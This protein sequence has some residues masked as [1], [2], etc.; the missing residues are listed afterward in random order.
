MRYPAISQTKSEP[1]PSRLRQSPCPALAARTPLL[2]PSLLAPPAPP[3]IPTAV[4]RD[5]L[6]GGVR[7]L[8]AGRAGSAQLYR[9]RAGSAQLDWYST[10]AAA[11]SRS[12]FPLLGSVAGWSGLSDR[13]HRVCLASAPGGTRVRGSGV[14]TAANGVAPLTGRRARLVLHCICIVYALVCLLKHPRTSASI[15]SLQYQSTRKT[16]PE[17]RSNAQLHLTTDKKKNPVT[18]PGR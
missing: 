9:R 3:F 13:A 18:S 5:P 14:C 17:N 16:S 6:Q 7:G 12:R 11:E 15:R 10:P 4:T 1:L 2:L 8:R